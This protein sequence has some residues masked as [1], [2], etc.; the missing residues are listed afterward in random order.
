MVKKVSLRT[1][2]ELFIIKNRTSV[3]LQKTLDTVDHDILLH[4]PFHYEVIVLV[5]WWFSSCLSSRKHFVTTNGFNSGTKSSIWVTSEV[6]TGSPSF[7]NLSL[8]IYIDDLHNVIK[9]SPSF[10][11]VD[12]TCLLNIP[13]TITKINRSLNKDLKE[14][15]FWVNANSIKCSKNRCHTLQKLTE[16]LQ[17]WIKA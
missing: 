6:C 13:N 15:S 12:D 9:F 3:D 4:K 10:H 7:L 17:Y 8:Y 5:N 2:S 11:F 1:E 14:L 16:T